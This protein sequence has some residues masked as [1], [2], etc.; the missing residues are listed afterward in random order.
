MSKGCDRAD[1]FSHFKQT[2]VKLGSENPGIF[3]DGS[4]YLDWIARSYNLQLNPN[5]LPRQDICSQT[6]QF[7]NVERIGGKKTEKVTLS[8]VKI[9]DTPFK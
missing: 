7:L 9:V 4:C 5:L 2:Q 8:S 3:T 1:I 6:K